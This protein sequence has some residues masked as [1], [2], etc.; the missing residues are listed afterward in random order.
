MQKNVCQGNLFGKSSA[1]IT[2][3]IEITL[4]MKVEHTHQTFTVL[5]KEFRV[6]VRQASTSD[7]YVIPQQRY[8]SH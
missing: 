7:S 2:D 4:K 1:I 3:P 8:D 5:M 6:A